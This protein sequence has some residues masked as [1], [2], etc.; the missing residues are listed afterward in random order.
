MQLTCNPLPCPKQPNR[1]LNV[2]KESR[3][4]D[5]QHFPCNA[6]CLS[7]NPAGVRGAKAL[8]PGN[9]K[10]CALALH[11]GS[12]RLLW[13][14]TAAVAGIP[15]HSQLFC[16]HPHC[17]VACCR[18]PPCMMQAHFSPSAPPTLSLLP[19]A[20]A[21]MSLTRRGARAPQPLWL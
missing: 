18:G 21:L 5:M 20:P 6:P 7:L 8:E 10:R 17:P 9:S 3:A 13:D 15:A 11:N 12:S 16:H 14:V 2:T 1:K 19:P 4:S